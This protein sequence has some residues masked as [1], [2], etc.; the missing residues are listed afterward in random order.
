MN[1]DF[2]NKR[3]WR[4]W[5]WN[6]IA[7]RTPDRKNA[8]VLFLAGESAFDIEA[9]SAKG[10]QP[11]NML[12]VE[13]DAKTI[14]KLRKSGVLTIEGDLVAVLTA[15]PNARPVGVVVAD[16]C[17]GVQKSLLDAGL[18]V[19]HALPHLADSV[20]A[21][22]FLRGRDPSFNH[23]RC[24]MTYR[25]APTKD[26]GRLF[27]GL[28]LE[29][30]LASKHGGFA[31]AFSAAS[32]HSDMDRINEFMCPA[33]M[34]YRSAAGTQRFDSVVF[35][36]PLQRMTGGHLPPFLIDLPTDEAQ[37]RRISAVLAHHTRR[38]A[39]PARVCQ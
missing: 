19:L 20:F 3:Q 7:E 24:R 33:H 28:V 30:L 18:H 11:C 38:C 25:G 36:A 8:L 26:R 16:F 21:F 4:R 29:Q 13:R 17:C 35:R 15:W 32:F 9:A 6:C 12:A 23:H 31:E 22:N 1:Y 10:F 14:A 34:S 37:R 39:A 27:Y 2:G 5:A